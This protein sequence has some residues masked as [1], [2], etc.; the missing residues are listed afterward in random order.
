MVDPRH[1]AA[2]RDEEE[3]MSA[4]PRTPPRPLQPARQFFFE[5]DIAFILAETGRILRERITMGPWV[6]ELERLGAEAAGTRHGIAVNN[7]TTALEII[8]RALPLGPGDE[9]LVPTQTFV[10]TALAVLH[11]GARPVP[12][13]IDPATHCLSPAGIE[14]RIGPRTRAAILVHY[15]G[16][17]TPDLEAIEDIC[18]ARRLALVEDCAH[19]HGAR[20]GDRLAGSIG[21]AGAFSFYA[22]KV[23][24][25]GEGGLIT[26]ND[27]ALAKVMRSYQARGQDLAVRD[28]EIFV[29]PGRSCRMTAFSG[30]CG[31]VQY[32]RLEELLAR[33]A[34]VVAMYDQ[35]VR[36]AAPDV[37]IVGAPPGT[38]HS[39]WKHTM[40]LPPG[41]S[42]AA[43][44]DLLARDYGVP[45]GWS[46]WPP[47]HLQPVFANLFGHRAGELPVS[48]EVMRRNVSL[49]MHAGLDEGDAR[50]V[51]DSFLD[52]FGRLRGAP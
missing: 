36:A 39:Y 33:R 19:A 28:E 10:A 15:G 8:L 48:E 26:T 47:V 4:Y 1:A 52:A 9:V 38:R 45:L 35:A 7:G 5:E 40:N 37:E 23:V 22:T 17:I 34:R 14:A 51:A 11:A 3:G 21:I 16:L 49:P 29:H 18:R 24:T 12:C 41:V 25:A 6:E 46:Y 31:T 43:L 30:L 50:Y 32:R 20:R 2:A 13:E 44:R 42:R 27:D